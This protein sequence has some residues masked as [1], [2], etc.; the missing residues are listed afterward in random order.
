MGDGNADTGPATGA[1]STRQWNTLYVGLLGPT[2]MLALLASSA[3][4]PGDPGS[5][6]GRAETVVA[7]MAPLLVILSLVAQGGARINGA[8]N[9]GLVIAPSFGAGMIAWWSGADRPEVTIGAV[10]LVTAVALQAVGRSSVNESHSA[11]RFPSSMELVRPTLIH[12]GWTFALVM[13]L[14]IDWVAR[15]PR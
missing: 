10:V 3:F 1:L 11:D 15:R 7:A 4:W 8:A 2:M 14:I 12:A 13:L 9:W 6:S 5:L